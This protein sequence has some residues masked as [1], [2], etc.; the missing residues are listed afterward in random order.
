MRSYACS[1]CLRTC[2]TG[3]NNY[4][5][6]YTSFTLPGC[7]V[8]TQSTDRRNLNSI[9]SQHVVPVWKN[10]VAKELEGRCLSVNLCDPLCSTAH[11]CRKCF[12]AYEKLLKATEFLS[13]NIKQVVDS[14]VSSAHTQDHMNSSCVTTENVCSL[15]A[16]TRK[17]VSNSISVLPSSKR[18]PARPSVFSS[19]HNSS[20][21]STPEVAVSLAVAT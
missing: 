3:Y 19:S 12:Y 6:S 17:R 11:M 21:P 1:G 16:V 4:Y 9:S 7:G 8:I 15:N 2:D 10:I 13:S 14:I 18:Q 5:G 20:Q